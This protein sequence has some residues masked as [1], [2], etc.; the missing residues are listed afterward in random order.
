MLI[1]MIENSHRNK[2]LVL[3][4]TNKAAD[5]L[6]NKIVK[7]YGEN[8]DYEKWLIRYGITNEESIEESAIFHG[9]EIDI[10]FYNKCVVVTTMARLP[11]DYFIDRNGNFRYLRDI[12][13][14]CIVVDEASMIPLVY[15]TY[16]L[17]K[18]T[19]KNFI[20]AG[21]PFQI[22]PT[23]AVTEWKSEN[24][25]E[26]VNLKE[27]SEEAETVPHRYDIKLLTTQYRSVESVGEIFSQFAD[28]GLLKHHRG[29]SEAKKLNIEKYLDY[30]NLNIIKFPVSTYESIYRPKKLLLSNYH[31]H[32]ALFAYEF[33]VY[34]AKALERANS[35]ENRYSIGIISPY[36]AQAGLISKLLPAADIPA[37]VDI[38]SGTI[39]GFQGDECDIV[40][41]VLN[42]PPYISQNKEMFLNR[43]NIINVAIS[44]AR[45]YLFVLMPDDK[46]K[47]VTSLSL[48]N[49]L[50]R[51]IDKDLHTLYST[52]ELEKMMFDD[53]TYLENNA[54]ATGHQAVNVY[55]EP[56]KRYEIRSEE[57]AID[58][59]IHGDVEYATFVRLDDEV[60]HSDV[61]NGGTDVI[62]TYLKGKSVKHSSFGTGV[63]TDC[64]D[65]NVTVS[66]SGEK[67][68]FQFPG[69]FEKF[70]VIEDE[71][72]RDKMRYY[73][74]KQKVDD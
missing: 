56:E 2:I 59:Q 20:V 40:I 24:I 8:S 34:I 28:G 7:S 65:K 14:D 4:P 45:D 1:Q 12:N 29:N 35:E 43:K 30:S 41:V 32:S 63:I 5:V 37:N 42:P 22:E 71:L 66:F 49:R 15:M 48:V 73:I 9:K 16:M 38:S 62:M 74:K 18:M 72:L 64:D 10:D 69:C 25:Y 17:Y 58:V 57:K 13:W 31:I 55:D 61:K 21:D 51:L 19:P 27:F 67:K 39:H 36:G 68:F 23:T 6:V 70:L 53:E 46:T 3:T 52:G 60:K 26:M 47:N 11:Y 54:F 44:R 50:N 33:A